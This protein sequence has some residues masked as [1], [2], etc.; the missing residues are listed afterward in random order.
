MARQELSDS[1]AAFQKS[2]LGLR[3]PNWRNT[4]DFADL[5]GVTPIGSGGASLHEMLVALG[6]NV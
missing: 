4:L 2:L 5:Y 1:G 6:F 3:I